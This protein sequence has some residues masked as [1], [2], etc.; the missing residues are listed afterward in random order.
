MNR[1]D[2]YN[3]KRKINV[4]IIGTASRAQSLIRTMIQLPDVKIAALCDL[5]KTRM[6]KAAKIITDAGLPLPKMH[7]DY[8]QLLNMKGLD[9]VI[10]ATAWNSHIP[11]C[12]DALN[13]GLYVGTEVGCASSLEECYELVR[14]SERTGKPCMT[15]ARGEH[16]M[17]LPTQTASGFLLLQRLHHHVI[18]FSH[19]QTTNTFVGIHIRK[20]TGVAGNITKEIMRIAVFVLFQI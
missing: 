4:L 19:I 17:D 20:H 3:M 13:A 6:E 10:V 2:T 5:Q 11:I 8:K 18:I 9:A 16:L 7:T 14:T 1:N 15:S 12:I